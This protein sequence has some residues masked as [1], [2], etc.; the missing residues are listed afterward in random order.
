MTRYIQNDNR[1]KPE[2]KEPRELPKAGQYQMDNLVG[3]KKII[4]PNGGKR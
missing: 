2:K 1:V 4:S 3:Q